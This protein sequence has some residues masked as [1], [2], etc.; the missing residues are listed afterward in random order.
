MKR[1]GWAGLTA[2]LLVLS[3]CGTETAAGGIP[4]RTPTQH[5][6]PTPRPTPTPPPPTCP[7]SGVS[8]SV[9]DFD[10]SVGHRAVIARLTNCRP[11]PITVTGYPD[12]TVLDSKRTTMK[13]TVTHGTSYMAIDPGPTKLRLRKGESA[14]AAI[15]WSSTVEIGGDNQNGAYLSVARAK[16][17]KPTVWP[18]VTDIGTTGKIALTAWSLKRP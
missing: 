6:T 5:A 17:E 18:V 1:R 2:V 8:I 12:V 10:A 4:K 13:V 15:A 3:G 11:E 14:Q 16:H 7:A 9:G